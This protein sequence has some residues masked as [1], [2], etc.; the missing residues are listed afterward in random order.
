METSIDRAALVDQY[1][2]GPEEVAAALAGA[3]EAELDARPADGGWTA[4]E[5]AHHLADSETMS[6][7]RLRRLLAEDEPLLGAYDENEFARRLH[8]DRPLAASLELFRAVR[9][10]NAELLERL[11]DED[12]S[13]TGT[14]SD[15][16]PY[17]VTTWLE[18]YGVHA[19]D[20]AD[21][22]RRA[23]AEAS[24]VT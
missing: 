23:R 21:Q 2:A 16:G 18:I 13:R 24:P 17:S 4:R 10:S 7:I 12:W 5:V 14:H 19:R 1:R 22:I 8:Y 6:V 9:A 11:S 15:S 3:T 20:H